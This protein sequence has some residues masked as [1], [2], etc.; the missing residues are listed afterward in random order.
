MGFIRGVTTNPT[1]MFKDGLKGG[2]EEIKKRIKEIS[3]LAMPYPVSVELLTNDTS[4]MYE[5]AKDLASINENI[6][7]VSSQKN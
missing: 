1:I 4:Q 7:M 2:Y 6:V 3:D 5:Q